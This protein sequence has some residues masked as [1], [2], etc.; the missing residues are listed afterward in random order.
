MVSRINSGTTKKKKEV[1][2]SC[3]EPIYNLELQCHLTV[4]KI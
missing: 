2:Q 1:T 4:N 3:T